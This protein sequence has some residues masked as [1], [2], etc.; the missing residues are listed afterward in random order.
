MLGKTVVSYTAFDLHAPPQ[1][2]QQW[3]GS[4][5][6]SLGHSTV[7][8]IGYLGDRGFHLQQAHLINNALPRARADSAAAALQDGQ[9]PGRDRVSFDH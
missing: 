3:S 5:E 7:L 1:Y 6:K 2:V 9:L 8:E 4:L